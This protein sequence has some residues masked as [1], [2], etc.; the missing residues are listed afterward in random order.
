MRPHSVGRKG[1]S[2]SRSFLY[3]LDR[4][5]LRMWAEGYHTRFPGSTRRRLV[6]RARGRRHTRRGARR[7]TKIELASS[8]LLCASPWPSFTHVH[9]GGGIEYVRCL[10]GPQHSSS[11][12]T[13]EVYCQ[14]ERNKPCTQAFEQS[15]IE[16]FHRFRNL[17][18]L[19]V[20]LASMRQVGVVV[21]WVLRVGGPESVRFVN[22]VTVPIL[23]IRS[24][25][26][27]RP[28]RKLMHSDSPTSLAG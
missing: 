26:T 7:R 9:H 6:D 12:D 19:A 27:R 15:E 23:P 5:A 21:V 16:T 3:T 8:S 25:Q 14:T 11:V 1:T 2:L 10:V 18:P 24:F 17:R 20:G 22:P 13:T 4:L 28:S